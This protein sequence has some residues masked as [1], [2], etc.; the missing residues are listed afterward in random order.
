MPPDLSGLGSVRSSAV[1]NAE[2]RALVRAA[3]GLMY[4][5]DRVRYAGLVEE[6][7]QAVT[8]ERQLIDVGEAA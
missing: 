1:V 4:G 2:I 5:D 3:D 6:W 7:T 8:V